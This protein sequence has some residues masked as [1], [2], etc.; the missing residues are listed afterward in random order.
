MITDKFKTYGDISIYYTMASDYY[1]YYTA[2]IQSIFFMYGQIITKQIA[3][4][5][6]K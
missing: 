5:Y 1:Y 6:E 3:D 2:N 4:N